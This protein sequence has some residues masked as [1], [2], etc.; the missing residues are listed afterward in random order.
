MLRMRIGRGAVQ[1]FSGW[2]N[3]SSSS[4]FWEFLWVISDKQYENYVELCHTFPTSTYALNSEL[5]IRR[6][7]CLNPGMLLSKK[8]DCRVYLVDYFSLIRCWNLIINCIQN[9][10][11][12]L[13]RFLWSFFCYHCCHNFKVM[14][15][16]SSAAAVWWVWGELLP[17]VGFEIVRRCGV[18]Y[19]RYYVELVH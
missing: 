2:A 3:K 16:L 10:W 17:A 6:Y 14:K 15:L 13:C 8:T 18:I 5:K 11:R 12:I 7:R 1:K 4:S 19:E 9:L